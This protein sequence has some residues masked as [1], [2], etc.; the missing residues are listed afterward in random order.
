[1]TSEPSGIGA[2]TVE[3]T[4]SSSRGVWILAGEREMFMPY[5]DF[6]WFEDVPVSQTIKV[7][8]LRPGRFYWPD[9]DVDLG[10]ASIENP[11]RFPL[12]AARGA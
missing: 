10:L 1:M 4:S 2:S 11:N 8:E 3:V 9:L 5:K 7:N 12:K 6:P